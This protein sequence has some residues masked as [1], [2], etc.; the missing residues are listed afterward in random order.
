MTPCAPSHRKTISDPNLSATMKAFVS[1]VT[2]V[3]SL[4]PLGAALV[5]QTAP[6]TQL[7]D[8]RPVEIVVKQHVESPPDPKVVEIRA[9]APVILRTKAAFPT[10]TVK[11]G[12]IITFEWLCPLFVRP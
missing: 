7:P 1:R 5:A 9:G 6:P 10:K 2:S 4:L 8:S 3:F 12:D 11:T